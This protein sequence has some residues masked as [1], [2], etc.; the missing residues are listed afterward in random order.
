MTFSDIVAKL[1]YVTNDELLPLTSIQTEEDKIE[2][3][4]KEYSPDFTEK[5]WS[6]KFPRLP[7]E[8]IYYLPGFNVGM[9]YYD[10]EK[11]IYLNLR[12]Y[13]GEVCIPNGKDK[14]EDTILN[15]IQKEEEWCKKKEYIRLF[16]GMP[17]GLRMAAM[18]Q[19][20]KL[21][22]PTSHF[23]ET[24]MAEY[25][26]CDF[27]AATLPTDIVDVLLKSKSEEQRNE[28]KRRLDERFPDTDVIPV[29]RGM[30]DKST[31]P[32][33]AFSWSPDINVAVFF[34]AHLGSYGKVLQGE[35]RKKDIIE[36][37]RPEDEDGQEHEVFV[38]PGS[39]V[40]KKTIW[41]YEPD[42]DAL[43]EAIDATKDIYWDKAD[44]LQQLY[45]GERNGGHDCMHSLRVL[46]LSLLIGHML[47]FTDEEL[48][49]VADA[50][51]YHDTG[52]TNDEEDRSHGAASARIYQRQGGSNKKVAFAIRTHCWPDDEQ[53]ELLKKRF[54][55]QAQDA[56]WRIA[57]VLKDADALDRVRFGIAGVDNSK[58]GLDVNYLRNEPSL[59]LVGVAKKA[60]RHLEM[61]H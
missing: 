23:Y 59:R 55:T 16:M 53:K 38:K 14:Y 21:E 32:D 19:I 48:N 22:G 12:I 5:E 27:P 3:R 57:S 7:A 29:F 33:K 10:M 39:V 26:A 17:D 2:A 52:R 36:Y 30:A 18:Q 45:P 58:D 6:E 24:F 34:A 35:V 47:D 13:D 28:T 37:F 8:K 43:Q 31:A 11:V 51:I 54:P 15:L 1:N 25:T 4:K 60:L 44:K 61:P 40:I 50:A 41:M 9:V 20:L 49:M 46:F 42:E 56:V